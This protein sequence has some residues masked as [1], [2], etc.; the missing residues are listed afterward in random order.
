[1]LNFQA[2]VIEQA[3]LPENLAE[4]EQPHLHIVEDS[5]FQA[6]LL[7]Q[8]QSVYEPLELWYLRSSVEKAHILDEAD[9][10]NKPYLSSSLDDTFFILK[11]VLSRLITT[12]SLQTHKRMCAEITI[13]ME[14]DFCDV[15]RKGMDAVWST[16]TSS[17]QAVRIK[18]EN[19]ARQNFVVSN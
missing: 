7:R 11:K 2:P 16:V 5:T 6:N 10:S 19:Q 18:E 1:M 3:E 8:L 12:S 13:I 15:L 9:F 14:R 4:G 17:T